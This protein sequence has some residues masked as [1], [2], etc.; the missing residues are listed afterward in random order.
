MLFSH[1][2]KENK[3][4]LKSR[5]LLFWNKIVIQYWN[6]FSMM[7]TYLI[8]VI[9]FNVVKSGWWGGVVVLKTF[10]VTLFES[11]VHFIVSYKDETAQFWILS[12]WNFC[13]NTLFITSSTS[14][15]KSTNSYKL[16]LFLGC[17]FKKILQPQTNKFDINTSTLC[18][19]CFWNIF[20]WLY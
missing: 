7:V 17:F 10:N 1:Y 9:R 13:F 14:D 11:W 3:L 19:W 18:L 2:F 12:L 20:W 15:V 4:Y 8:Y 6:D 5:L 16:D